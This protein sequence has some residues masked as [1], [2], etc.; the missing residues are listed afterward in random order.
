M[1]AIAN[2]LDKAYRAFTPLQWLHI[3][4]SPQQ[5]LKRCINGLKRQI[6]IIESQMHEDCEDELMIT[7][8]MRELARSVNYDQVNMQMLATNLIGVKR[9][10]AADLKTRQVSFAA[11][12][13]VCVAS[14]SI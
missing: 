6:S 3:R 2:T 5:R 12:A 10:R 1:D 8:D 11:C 9:R 7:Q 14:L 4:S 13:W